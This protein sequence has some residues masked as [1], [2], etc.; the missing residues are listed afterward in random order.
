MIMEKKIDFLKVAISDAQE[1]I[2]FTDSK[3]AIIITIISAYIVAF[4]TATDKI[5][6]YSWGYSACFWFF[7]SL[8]FLLLV[9]CIIVTAR[10]IKPTNNPADNISLGSSAKPNLIFF[11]APN[12]Y[13]NDSFYSFYNSKKF[14][15]KEDYEAYLKQITIASEEDILKSLTFELLKVSYIRNIKNDRFQILLWL[16]FGTTISFFIC[17][18]IFSIET[19]QAMDYIEEMKNNCCSQ[20]F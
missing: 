13:L 10:I 2:R 9:L 6:K 4:Y 19:Q 16:L 18:F 1:L 14:K 15:L 7:L 5:V 8:F 3:T 12:N 20:C 11:L 17:F